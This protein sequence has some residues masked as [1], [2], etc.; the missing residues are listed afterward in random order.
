MLQENTQCT[1][2]KKIDKTMWK[3]F[4]NKV[5]RY[6]CEKC[7][8]SAK[9]TEFSTRASLGGNVSQVCEKEN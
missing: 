2:C 1:Y 4:Y 5:L 9:E 6:Y 7:W 8:E 3:V